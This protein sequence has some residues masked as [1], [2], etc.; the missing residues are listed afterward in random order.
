MCVLFHLFQKRG[1][2]N[3]ALLPGWGGFVFFILAHNCQVGS[4]SQYFL[5]GTIIVYLFAPFD[6]YIKGI[7]F[8][9]TQYR[10]RLYVAEID[11]LLREN[12]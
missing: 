3:E 11:V 6:V 8:R 12:I 1:G 9:L 4:M 5:D 2:G 10:H 7:L